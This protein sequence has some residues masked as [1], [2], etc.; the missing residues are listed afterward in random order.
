MITVAGRWVSRCRRAGDH[1]S[2]RE[3]LELIVQ[4]PLA[5]ELSLKLE[6]MWVV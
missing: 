2:I 1:R 4:P 6:H 5:Y 3:L